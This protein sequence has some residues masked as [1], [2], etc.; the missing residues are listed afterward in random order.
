MTPRNEDTFYIKNVDHKTF[1]FTER[2]VAL[3]ITMEA[4][5]KRKMINGASK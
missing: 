5:I 3:W 1:R 2:K 4:E